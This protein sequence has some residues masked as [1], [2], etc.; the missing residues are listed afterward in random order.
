MALEQGRMLKNAIEKLIRMA[1][2][3]PSIETTSSCTNNVSR[4]YRVRESRTRRK[5][6]T[7][8]DVVIA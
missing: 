5:K 2:A 4:A 1:I 6:S 3:G 7:F 8:Q